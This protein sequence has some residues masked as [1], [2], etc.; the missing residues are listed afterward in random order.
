MRTSLFALLAG[1]FVMGFVDVTGIATN[2]IRQ[3][4]GLPH[5]VANLLPMAVFLWFAVCS[6]PTG[7]LMNRYGKKRVVCG[8]LLLTLVA[9]LVPLAAYTYP[10]LQLAFALLGISNT[11]LQVSINPL[12]ATAVQPSLLASVLTWGQFIKA[13][14]AFLGPVIAS[15]AALWTGQWKLIFALYALITLANTLWI[16]HSV[17]ATHETAEASTFGS[18]LSLFA[19]THI[20]R[21]FIGILMIVGIDVS[22]NTCIPPLLM[23]HTGLPLE[24]AGLGT[25]LYFLSRTA[26]TFAGALLLTRY[27]SDTFLRV[28]MAAALPALAGLAFCHVSI[29]LYAAIVL[30][31][32][33]YANVF[34]ILF[35]AALQYRPGRNNDISSLMVMGVAG[36]ALFPPLMGL[37]ADQGSQAMS[38]LIP[39]AGTLYLLAVKP[40]RQY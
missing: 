6:V 7:L 11:A 2:Y 29:A 34:S 5:A 16:A 4:F 19:D 21:L 1:F 3:D 36:G 17:P 27:P 14:S 32:L 24:Q 13:V 22:L 35:A 37:I 28:S 23:A 12:T 9:L 31:G 38:L 10:T 20:L 39:A 18:T 15:A 33:A 26:G 30:A 40:S 8:S 25:S